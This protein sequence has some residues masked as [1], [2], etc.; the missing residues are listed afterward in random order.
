MEPMRPDEY[1]KA[2]RAD[3]AILLEI[4]RTTPST[5]SVPSCPDWSLRDLVDHI[6]NVQ[7]GWHQVATKPLVSRDDFVPPVSPEG[8]AVIEWFAQATQALAAA[9][10]AAD[11]ADAAWTWWPP[12]QTVGFIQRRMAQEVAVHRWDA[13]A[14]AGRP[15]PIDAPLADDGIA[16]FFDIHLQGNEPAV[17]GAGERLVFV[18]TDTESAWTATLG[19]EG[20]AI[21]HDSKSGS[22]PD[23]DVTCSGSA[24]DMLLMLWG[25]IPVSRMQIAG[26][27]ALLDGFL[28]RVDLS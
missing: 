25:R 19:P 9:L 3:S 22:I 13:Q 27:A 2:L 8:E 10:E 14:T 4:A 17:T 23:A 26:D 12:Q 11:P 20:T 24:S 15:L 7:W 1:I 5:A 16:E 21:V 6:G 18:T 28:S